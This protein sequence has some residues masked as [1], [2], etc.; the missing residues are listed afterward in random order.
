MV[1]HELFRIHQRPQNVFKGLL[2]LLG[3]LRNVRGRNPEFLGRRTPREGDEIKIGNAFLL[4][5]VRP[6]TKC[7]RSRA[8]H[9]VFELPRN[10]RDAGIEPS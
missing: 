6:W 9:F 5:H 2:G 7:L 8:T 10:S 3:T 1:E 4:V